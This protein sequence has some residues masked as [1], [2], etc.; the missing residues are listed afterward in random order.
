MYSSRRPTALLYALGQIALVL[1]ATPQ[2]QAHP[3]ADARLNAVERQLS[4]TP[5]ARL[6]VEHGKA[7][8]QAG[9]WHEALGDAD[10]ALAL[11]PHLAD[12]LLLRAE[13]R[14]AA[15]EVDQALL[16]VDALLAAQP[17]SAAAHHLRARVLRELGRLA[18]A[19]NEYD[20]FIGGERQ[21]LPDHYIERA[22][23]QAAQG[24]LDAAVSGIDAGIARLGMIATLQ[25]E[26]VDLEVRRDNFDAAAGRLDRLLERSPRQVFWLV[27]RAEVLV[28]A[29]KL[30]E[31]RSTFEAA[32]ALLP[33]PIRVAA[34]RQLQERIDAGLKSLPIELVHG[35]TKS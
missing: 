26:A 30:D 33:N 32:R 34:L 28:A 17:E 14:Y 18:E 13:V 6:Y 15:G 16:A 25:L 2:A 27:R 20:R 3:S 31:A 11:A 24:R 10:R 19:E 7:N 12:A 29:G 22:Q 8:L 4:E 1:F 21:P 9:R 35:D 23:V 5:S